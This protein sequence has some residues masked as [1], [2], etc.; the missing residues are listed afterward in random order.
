M[1]SA[2]GPVRKGSPGSHRSADDERAGRNRVPSDDRCAMPPCPC[3][4]RTRS[5]GRLPSTPSA[6]PGPVC[7]RCVA[8]RCRRGPRHPAGPGGWGVTVWG[9]RTGPGRVVG[10]VYSSSGVSLRVSV[11]CH[12]ACHSTAPNN[13]HHNPSIIS[14]SLPWVYPS[15]SRRLCPCRHTSH[16]TY[17]CCNPDLAWYPP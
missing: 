8:W 16:C 17:S 5:R 10:W 2:I 7:R 14:P 6:T 1:L 13:A 9:G 12:N 11:I 15:P 4:M 3:P